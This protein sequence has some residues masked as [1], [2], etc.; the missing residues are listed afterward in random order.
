VL[1]CAHLVQTTSPPPLPFCCRSDS[2]IITISCFLQVWKIDMAE[3]LTIW[4]VHWK[5]CKRCI[6]ALP[7]IEKNNSNFSLLSVCSSWLCFGKHKWE[8]LSCPPPSFINCLTAKFEPFYCHILFEKL[9]GVP[10]LVLCLII[11]LKEKE[12]LRKKSELSS[13]FCYGFCRLYQS[14]KREHTS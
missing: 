4:H 8:V 14:D 11:L 3:C 2:I 12:I 13:V 5:S 1:Y 10:N 7:S 6:V 9:K